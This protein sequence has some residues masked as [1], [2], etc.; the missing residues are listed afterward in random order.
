[1]NKRIHVVFRGRVQGIGFRFTAESV[2]ASLGVVGWVKNLRGGDVEVVAEEK[3]DIL[4][5]FI[6]RLEEQFSGYITDKEVAWED[7]TGEF[8]EF[9]IRF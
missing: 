9:G 1:V 4:K 8:K 5:D 7:A 3:E 6:S 2:A